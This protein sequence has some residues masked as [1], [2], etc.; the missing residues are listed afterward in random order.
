MPNKKNIEE[1]KRLSESLSNAKAVYFTEFHGLNVGEITK[2]RSQFFK[3][4]IEFKVAKN[5]LVKLA[6]KEN[7]IDVADELLRGSTALAISFDEP[8]AP[9]KV[10]KKFRKHS[11]LPEV[12]GI[13][14]D[15]EFVPGSEYVRLADLP[16]KEELLAKLL[17]ML[18]SPLQKLASTI[19]A[20]MQDVLGVL[21]NL[22]ENKS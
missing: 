14:F 15:G 20:P 3:A 2:L 11:D 6:A 8:V 22:K 10:I 19:N 7:N 4:D 12:K 5:T 21:N 16:S 9:A 13:F 17:S 1:L 18:N